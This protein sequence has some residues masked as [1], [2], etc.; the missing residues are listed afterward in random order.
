MKKTYFANK[1]DIKRSWYIV[2][3][4]DQILGRLAARVATILRGKHKP[5]YTPHIDSGDGVIV[6]NASG[7]RVTGKKLQEKLYRRHSGYPGG[8]REIKLE[9]M[10][11]K[12]PTT[13]IKLAVRRMLPQGPLA[14][15]SIK[16][17]KV[18]PSEK[19]PHQGQRPIPLEV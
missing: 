16:K 18:Y 1:K 10:L 13:V 8:L 14:R 6:I 7:I 3:A 2:D 4:K 9:T 15:D 17:L 5:I 12:N 19:H 11:E